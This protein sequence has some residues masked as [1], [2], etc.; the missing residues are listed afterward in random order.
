MTLENF[1]L[2]R[3]LSIDVAPVGL[4]IAGA[5]GSGKTSLLE[6][7]LLLSTT[8]SRRGVQ[9]ADLIHHESGRDLGVLPYARIIGEVER[10]DGHARIEIAIERDEQRGATRKALRVAD[11]PRKAVDVVGLLP[12]VSFAPEDLELVIGSPSVR[13][14][15]LD[16]LLSQTDRQY[17]RRLARYTR[18][19]SHRNGLLRRTNGSSAPADEFEYWDEQLVG[20]GAYILAARAKANE[21]LNASATAYFQMLAPEAGRLSTGYETSLQ[22]PEGWWHRLDAAK[23]APVDL[24][25]WFGAAFEKQLRASLRDDQ[26]RGATQ[27]GPHRDDVALRLDGRELARFGSRGQQRMAVVALKLAEIAYARQALGVNPVFLLDDVLSEL[28]PEHR[29]ALLGTVR[30]SGSQLLVSATETGLL[31]TSELADLPLAILRAPGSL[32]YA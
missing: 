22:Q 21:L 17:M 11:R 14:R 24:A 32:D 13:R 7:V 1:R 31:E 28:D 2:Y 25:Q 18:I 3:E 5:N 23:R 6:S 30:G 9:D 4:R 8:R 27:A 10:P 26:L 12:T 29:A 15:F 19:L 20:L 16:V